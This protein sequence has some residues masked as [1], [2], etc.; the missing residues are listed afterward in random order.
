M[1]TA[2][3]RDG[4]FYPGAAWHDSES[5]AMNTDSKIP[6]TCTACHRE[7]YLGEATWCRWDQ[8]EQLVMRLC[9]GCHQSVQRNAARIIAAAERRLDELRGQ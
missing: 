6:K 4:G 1:N 8:A 9:G 2:K 5:Q 7:I 3:E